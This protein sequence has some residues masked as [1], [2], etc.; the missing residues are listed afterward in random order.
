MTLHVHGDP[1]A[2]GAREICGHCNEY[3]LPDLNLEKSGK[4]SPSQPFAIHHTDTETK[5]GQ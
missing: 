1:V 2:V 4:A 5:P 3:A